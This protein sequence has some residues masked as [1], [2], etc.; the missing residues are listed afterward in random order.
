MVNVQELLDR[1]TTYEKNIESYKN[2]YGAANKIIIESTEEFER[3][4]IKLA[5]E[6]KVMGIPTEEGIISNPTVTDVK[7]AVRNKLFDLYIKL[8]TQKSIKEANLE[9]FKMTQV[10]INAVQSKLNWY[11][12]ELRVPTSRNG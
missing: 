4:S 6:Y 11:K 2:K 10:Q 3:E 1:L 7:N 12:E 9:K 8:E 5:L